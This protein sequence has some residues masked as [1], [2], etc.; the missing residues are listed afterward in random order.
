METYTF[1]GMIHDWNEG[2]DHPFQIS[3]VLAP[4]AD[5]DLMEMAVQAIAYTIA[6]KLSAEMK[7]QSLGHDN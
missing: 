4:D 6:E 5:Q 3:L 1:Q 2:V 7:E